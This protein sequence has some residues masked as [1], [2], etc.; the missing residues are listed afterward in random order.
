MAPLSQTTEKIIY[1]MFPIT[2]QNEVREI[3]INKCGN[4]L[5]FL[6]ESDENGVERVRFAA[7]KISQGKLEK[8]YEAV[9]LANIDWRDLLVGAEFENDIQAHKK[10]A[11]NFLKKK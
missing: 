5:P 7:L 2:N 3:L 1:K 9:K 11:T 8:L 4:N 10:W 6:L